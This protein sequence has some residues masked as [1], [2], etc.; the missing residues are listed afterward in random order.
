[1]WPMSRLARYF[2]G[3]IT[4][5]QT[6]AEDSGL[7][8]SGGHADFLCLFHG[9]L[10]DRHP[11]APTGFHGQETAILSVSGFHLVHQRSDQPRA[12]E[13]ERSIKTA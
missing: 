7:G 3:A 8:G 6:G 2:M 5:C 12:S 10:D 1:M 9:D 4:H 11:L 13:D